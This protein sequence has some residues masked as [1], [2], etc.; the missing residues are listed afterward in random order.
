MS[1]FTRGSLDFRTRYNRA[2]LVYPTYCST[3]NAR[4]VC[5]AVMLVRCAEPGALRRSAAIQTT[6][7]SRRVVL[8]VQIQPTYDSLIK[9]DTMSVEDL[10]SRPVDP[11]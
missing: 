5:S 1:R 3:R 6:S 7:R 8:F 11:S 4:K 2:W 9:C 10:P